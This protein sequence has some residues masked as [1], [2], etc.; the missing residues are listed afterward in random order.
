MQVAQSFNITTYVHERAGILDKYYLIK[1]G[2]THNL[3]LMKSEIDVCYNESILPD[4]EKRRIA[5]EWYEERINN[6]PQSWISYTKN[7]Q[8]NFLPRSITNV[9]LE[10]FKIG[11]F[12]SSEDEVLTFEEW[13]NT[14]YQD[15]NDGI[16]RILEAFKGQDLIKFFLRVHPNLSNINNS[17]TRD[18]DRLKIQF[19]NLEVIDAKSIVSTYALIDACDLVITFG[20]TVGIEAVYRNKPSIL[21]GRAM[22]EDLGGVIKPSNHE[23]LVLILTNFCFHRTLPDVDNSDLG[24]IKY[25][26]FQKMY[27]YDFE[28]VKPYE[29]FKVSLI[30]NGKEIFIKSSFVSRVLK[31]LN[32]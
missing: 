9:G 11:I 29:A 12:N 28:Y 7:Q 8:K 18:I 25:G 19:D 15:Q 20:S 21:M 2:S 4:S 5:Y 14:L 24:V 10:K 23:E 3:S 22:Y 32:L 13:E 27:G 16:Y 31:K 26:F 6:N 17:Q 1:N 30:K